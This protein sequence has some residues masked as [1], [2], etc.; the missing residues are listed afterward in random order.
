VPLLS[1]N[2]RRFT[3]ILK[4]RSSHFL[5]R[6]SLHQPI[7]A[8]VRFYIPGRISESGTPTVRGRGGRCNREC[9]CCTTLEI[10]RETPRSESLVKSNYGQRVAEAPLRPLCSLGAQFLAHRPPLS[11]AVSLRPFAS[12]V[13]VCAKTFRERQKPRRPSVGPSIVFPKSTFDRGPGPICAEAPIRLPIPRSDGHD[14]NNASL[15]Q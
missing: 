2:H 3:F 10:E 9:R 5:P 11:P 6:L 1:Q 14:Y 8:R 4:P 7:A 13:Q 15:V 12:S